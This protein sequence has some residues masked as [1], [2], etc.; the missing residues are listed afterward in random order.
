MIGSDIFHLTAR[1]RVVIGATKAKTNM[2]QQ[3]MG[4][5]VVASIG[6]VTADV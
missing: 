2:T 5:I 1:L 6:V 4:E 3:S